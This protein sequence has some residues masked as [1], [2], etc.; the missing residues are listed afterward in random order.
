MPFDDNLVLHDGT[1][2][3]A[4]ISPT[5]TSRISG[6]AVIDLRK[7]NVKGL[8]AIMFLDEDLAEADDL[9]V[10]SIEESSD[11][12]TW[13]ELARFP[14]ITSAA[15]ADVVYERAIISKLRY[16]RAKI[17]I[18]DADSGGDFTVANCR[19]LLSLHRL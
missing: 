1:T 18:T 13:V 10:I 4:D 19:V 2:I 5:S 8:F 3:T 15:T 17:D 9:M 14:V 12:A 16:I 6:S 11:L 7:T